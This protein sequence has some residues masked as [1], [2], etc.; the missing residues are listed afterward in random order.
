[1]QVKKKM[2]SRI[3]AAH[4]SIVNKNYQSGF[5]AEDVSFFSGTAV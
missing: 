2:R 5:F 4:L 1:M 3:T